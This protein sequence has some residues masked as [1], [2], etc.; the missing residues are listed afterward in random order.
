MNEFSNFEFFAAAGGFVVFWLLWAWEC[1]GSCNLKELLR[2]S[3]ASVTSLLRENQS[4]HRELAEY[5][6]CPELEFDIS[7]DDDYPDGMEEAIGL[8]A[9]DDE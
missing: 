7:L 4:L 5:E 3:D 9:E 6:E 8:F 1:R 2:L